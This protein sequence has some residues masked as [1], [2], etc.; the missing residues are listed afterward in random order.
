[1][2]VFALE[3]CHKVMETKKKKKKKEMKKVMKSICDLNRHIQILK[4]DLRTYI[5]FLE[6][7]SSL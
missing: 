4:T 1:M 7:P 3:M 5:F 2:G 6:N